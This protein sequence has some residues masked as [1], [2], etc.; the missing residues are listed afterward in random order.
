MDIARRNAGKNG[1]DISNLEP[2]ITQAMVLEVSDSGKRRIWWR[3]RMW[4]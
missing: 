3:A 4:K 2:T 1:I